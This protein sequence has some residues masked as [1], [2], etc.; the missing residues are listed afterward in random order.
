MATF[1]SYDQLYADP[2]Y[3]SF[4]PEEKSQAELGLSMEFE[5]EGESYYDILR[6]K[7]VSS[8]RTAGFEDEQ[9]QGFTDLRKKIKESPD[10]LTALDPLIE[11][12]QIGA[13]RNYGNALS[14][15]EGLEGTAWDSQAAIPVEGRRDPLVRVRPFPSF[16]SHNPEFDLIGPK[17]EVKH[18]VTGPDGLTEKDFESFLGNLREEYSDD[19]DPIW[20]DYAQAI[21]E[22]LGSKG[23]ALRAVAGAFSRGAASTAT[24]VGGLLDA[25][26]IPGSDAIGDKLKRIG[27]LGDFDRTQLEGESPL[28]GAAGTVASAIGQL[29]TQ[30]LAGGAASMARANK[31][32]QVA[33]FTATGAGSAAGNAY[34]DSMAET[35]DERAAQA[36]AASVFFTTAVLEWGAGRYF[37]ELAEGQKHILRRAMAGGAVEGGTEVFQ[38]AAEL[39]ATQYF[40]DNTAAHDAVQGLVD[41]LGGMKDGSIDLKDGFNTLNENPFVAALIGGVGA[42][43][44]IGAGGVG[45]GVNARGETA[46]ENAPDIAMG[47]LSDPSATPEQQQQLDEIESLLEMGELDPDERAVAEGERDALLAA[48][49]GGDA[50]STTE[51]VAGDGVVTDEEV[52]AESLPA[53]AT[54]PAAIQ[55]EAEVAPQGTLTVEEI[56]RSLDFIDARI[57]GIDAN[58][59]NLDEDAKF[60]A[61]IKREELLDEMSG[62]QIE[63][64]RRNFYEGNRE[65]VIDNNMRREEVRRERAA[66]EEYQAAFDAQEATDIPPPA[67]TINAMDQELQQLADQEQRNQPRTPRGRDPLP[68]D[69]VQALAQSVEEAVGELPQEAMRILVDELVDTETGFAPQETVK[70]AISDAVGSRR[71]SGLIGREPIG[72]VIKEVMRSLRK[73]FGSAVDGMRDAIANAVY[74]VM[75]RLGHINY[76]TSP[77]SELNEMREGISGVFPGLSDEAVEQVAEVALTGRAFKIPKAEFGQWLTDMIGEDVAAYGEEIYEHVERWGSFNLQP[78]VAEALAKVRGVADGRTN[79]RANQEPAADQR[80]PAAERE[81]QVAPGVTANY[82]AGKASSD[83]FDVLNDPSSRLTEAERLPLGE[84][85]RAFLAAALPDA[86]SERGEDYRNPRPLEEDYEDAMLRMD[87]EEAFRSMGLKPI[88]IPN[89]MRDTYLDGGVESDVYK[90]REGD[91]VYKFF[92]SILLPSAGLISYQMQQAEVLNR[93]FGDDLRLEGYDE[94]KMMPVWSQPFYSEGKPTTLELD[95]AIAVAGWTKIDSTYTSDDNLWMFFDSHP[96]NW[97]K[98]DGGKRLI[99]IDIHVRFAGELDPDLAN[100]LYMN[101]ND[102]PMALAKEPTMKSSLSFLD[103]MKALGAEP[104]PREFPVQKTETIADILGMSTTLDPNR[105]GETGALNL[106]V[107]AD[108]AMMLY[109]A[110]GS[111]AEFADAMAVRFG[112]F[113]GEPAK[114][115]FVAIDTGGEEALHKVVLANFARPEDSIPNAPGDTLSGTN[116]PP[117][118]ETGGLPERGRGGVGRDPGWLPPPGSPYPPAARPALAGLPATV[119]VDGEKVEFGPFE[120]AR[121]AAEAYAA[122]EGFATEPPRTYAKVDEARAT[123]IA[124]DFEAMEHDP[125]D[126]EVAASY[127]AMI[128]ETLAQYQALQDTGLVVEVMPGGEDVYGNPRNAVLDVVENNHL[129]FFPTV[130][131]FGGGQD[132]DVTD[133]PLLEDTGI[134]LPDGHRMLANDVFRVVHDYFGHIKEGVGFRAD[135]EENAWRQHSTMYSDLARPAMTTETR[136][137]NSWVNYGPH[138]EFNRTATSDTVFAPQKIGILPDYAMTEGLADPPGT[139]DIAADDAGT[140]AQAEGI[141]SPPQGAG[142]GTAE[143]DDGLDGRY[144]PPEIAFSSGAKRR[145][146]QDLPDGEFVHFPKADTPELALVGVQPAGAGEE[147]LSAALFPDDYI[148]RSYWGGNGYLVEEQFGLVADKGYK[149]K[150]PED[151]IYDT[152]A[153]PLDVRRRAREEMLARGET[154]PRLQAEINMRMIRE[155]GYAGFRISAPGNPTTGPVEAF[156][157]LVDIPTDGTPPQ[158]AGKGGVI[159]FIDGDSVEINGKTFQNIPSRFS[160]YRVALVPAQVVEDRGADM[161]GEG[162]EYANQIGTRIEGFKEYFATDAPIEVPEVYVNT[163]GAIIFGNGRHRTRVLLEEG[164]EEIPMAMQAEAL[165]NLNRAIEED[166][167]APSP[168]QQGEIDAILAGAAVAGTNAP[169][170]E[171]A[172]AEISPVNDPERVGTGKLGSRKKPV[173]TPQDSNISLSMVPP[174]ALAAQMEQIGGE[175]YEHVP[176]SILNEKDDARKARRYIKWMKE[177]ILALYDAVDPEVRVRSARWYEGARAIA[178]DLSARYGIEPRQA[179]AVIAGL[180]PQK[181]WFMNVAQAEQVIDIW[182]NHQFDILEGDAV[183]AQIE[184][185]IGSAQ[186]A[187]EQRKRRR[188]MD[189]IRGRS[190]AQLDS[191][192]Y[193]QAWAVRLLAQ[194]IYGQR[195]SEI[196]PEGTPGPAITKKDGGYRNNTWGSV[197]EIIKGMK[198]LQDGSL[199]NISDTIG[200][201]HKVRSFYNNII[202]PNSGMGD[203]TADTHA[204]AAAHLLPIGSADILVSHSLSGKGSPVNGVKGHYHLYAE[205]YRQAAAE[206]DVLP[207]QMQSVTWEAV[208]SLWTPEAK[209]DEQLVADVRKT[210][211]RNSNVR[212]REQIL[213]YG[214]LPPSWARSRD[215]GEPQDVQAATQGE[216]GRND[217]GGSLRFRGEIERA[218]RGG[219]T[220]SQLSNAELQTFR[221]TFDRRMAGQAGAINF[222]VFADAAKSIWRKGIGLADFVSNMTRQLG[223]R[224]SEVATELWNHLTAR[225]GQEGRTAPV[226]PPRPAGG[227]QVT[228]PSDQAAAPGDQ[229]ADPGNAAPAANTAVNKATPPAAKTPEQRYREK[230]LEHR[231]SRADA[232]NKKV[233]EFA[234][235]TILDSRIDPGAQAQVIDEYGPITDITVLQAS[236][237]YVQNNGVIETARQVIAGT[238]PAG[239]ENLEATAVAQEAMLQLN[240]MIFKGQTD[241]EKDGYRVIFGDLAAAEG[242]NRRDVARSLRYSSIEG[243]LDAATLRIAAEKVIETANRASRKAGSKA[244]AKD[245]TD[246]QKRRLQ[247]IGEKTQELREAGKLGKLEEQ[248]QAAKAAQV[249]AES[250]PASMWEKVR[251]TQ[252]IAMLLN[253]KTT[254]RNIVGNTIFSIASTTSDYASIPFDIGLSIV[255]SGGRTRTFQGVTRGAAEKLKAIGYPIEV[256]QSG[257]ALS[258]ET[259]L[260]RLLGAGIDAIIATSRSN[261]RGKWGIEDINR[262]NSVFES[263]WGKA[264]ERA[265]GLALGTFDLIAYRG[266]YQNSIAQQLSAAGVELITDEMI[267]VAQ[268]EALSAIFQDD[269]KLGKILE[270]TKQTLNKIGDEYTKGK[271]GFGDLLLKFTRT[272]A[273][274]FM[275]G[276]GFSP[277][278]LALDLAGHFA[279]NGRTLNQRQL[280]ESFG[281]AATGTAGFIMMGAWMQ[282]MGLIIHSDDDDPDKRQ[283]DKQRGLFGRQINFSAVKRMVLSMDFSTPQEKQDGD[284]LGSYDWALPASLPMAMGAEMSA[285]GSWGESFAKGIQTLEEEPMLQ[286]ITHA[287]MDGVAAT[288]HDKSFWG[289]IGTG[290]LTDAASSFVPTFLSQVNRSF[291]DPVQRDA[292]SA[293]SPLQQSIDGVKAKLPFLSNDLPP[294]PDTLTGDLARYEGYFPS[295]VTMVNPMIDTQLKGSPVLD[296]LN[297]IYEQTGDDKVIPRKVTNTIAIRPEGEEVNVQHRLSP[298]EKSQMQ[299]WVGQVTQATYSELMFDDAEFA[300]MEPEGKAEIMGKALEDIYTAGKVL[301]LGHRPTRLSRDAAA[302]V[303]EAIEANPEAYSTELKEWM[304]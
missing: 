127:R 173:N 41:T 40:R 258:S 118:A 166:G 249:T 135:G 27:D 223:S 242:V 275:K 80:A 24:G 121:L 43:A 1:E 212:A 278:G 157:G 285:G 245:L 153:D 254:I 77:D 72:S 47:V 16:Q 288:R 227:D 252:T 276:L 92:D 88:Q 57:S 8:M 111:A 28:V 241:A 25:V 165:N 185:I 208:R 222:D 150:I 105:R 289:A 297:T 124:S 100:G 233:G 198:V 287:V 264:F 59:A 31:L 251:M 5:A 235:R 126:P 184:R 83:A 214:I 246:D 280:T 267:E 228:A 64:L 39:I 15:I 196:S 203:I 174:K 113:M 143:V 102:I 112:E 51:T 30:F 262:S 17:G 162:P 277:A 220:E 296:E 274:I 133:N 49:Q 263:K 300:K 117:V 44:A 271:F 293:E 199:E 171:D 294:K 213:R 232:K 175:G 180:S 187:K 19:S 256:F 178:D 179:A 163:S 35:G 301:V 21:D 75:E 193:N 76:A 9:I 87:R 95:A 67:R 160:G 286:G 290:L 154:D 20:G 3:Q 250:I 148:P 62:L 168:P 273:S 192:P 186:K 82:S 182:K 36:E 205:A 91:R 207:R 195:Y 74:R 302:L 12:G 55:A 299:Q 66:A 104:S 10:D 155:G 151:L 158:V 58:F 298:Q 219:V 295:W 216:G 123:R 226:R 48:L 170:A 125:Q 282:A 6:A 46:A 128:D 84:A 70:N 141:A 93:V 202:A 176:A 189:E 240:E 56:D 261:S 137:Q 108:T 190:V 32:G 114:E 257:V 243:R 129:Y 281:R 78:L 218:G 221:T 164:F 103:H 239:V 149:V 37:G 97:M 237:N 50:T 86:Q 33:A 23:G 52:A 61:N 159:E 115:M 209:R 167:G 156:V 96:G 139:A 71:K 238:I 259:K 303:D 138:G 283:L 188:I 107:V 116:P 79:V 284:V 197:S 191:D 63:R 253:P 147:R 266:A 45:P 144:S 29:S 60:E 210:W 169:P 119:R 200:L 217:A 7:T 94:S 85:R 109:R 99:P 292:Y 304:K 161:V 90:N 231:E 136:G 206:R 279:E 172:R 152:G 22:Q 268:A 81:I 110:A 270:N 53:P 11:S 101:G 54:D 248:I 13:F 204:V 120:P 68:A 260:T 291:I 272:P 26:P 224:V 89:R 181:D 106:D 18:V 142:R 247:E 69:P 265:L 177:N 230:L 225:P 42:G 2:D 194:S 65:E 146:V 14:A 229:V 255:G 215:A 236:K 140:A 122:K 4:T 132:L 73:S 201:M 38:T 145:L 34:L 183:E 131:G 98:T 211:K 134:V 244:Q 269:T 234:Q 130:S